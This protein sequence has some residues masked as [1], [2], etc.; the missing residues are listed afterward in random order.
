VD[1]FAFPGLDLMF[2]SGTM[3]VRSKQCKCRCCS[4]FF[5]PDFRNHERQH[6]C[7]K[8][9]CRQASKAASQ[10]RWLHKGANRD[11]FRGP[12]NVQRV[13]AWRQAHPGYGNKQTPF[14][15]NTQAAAPQ[16]PNLEQASCNAAP[17]L[18][19]A[20]Q[21][22]CLAKDPGFIGL[23]SMLT[24]TTLQEDIAATARR[25]VEQGQCILGLHLPGT[26]PPVY[27]RQTSAPTGSA[28]ASAAQL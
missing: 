20:L 8:P 11:Y 18:P 15:E 22:F 24:G 14:S 10:R 13:Q 1:G 21:D 17:C 27:D 23:L 25:V 26:T 9:A 19:G 16:R 12:L 7:A 28:T 5:F 3:S 4:E 6:Y 2:F